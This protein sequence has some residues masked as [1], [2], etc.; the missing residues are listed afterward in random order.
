MLPVSDCSV[1][2]MDDSFLK[3]QDDFCQSLEDAL[4]EG[5]EELW[6]SCSVR[7]KW[8]AEDQALAQKPPYEWGCVVFGNVSPD[9]DDKTTIE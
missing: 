3:S 9:F 2:L 8:T 7:E 5:E 6:E 4:G 1:H